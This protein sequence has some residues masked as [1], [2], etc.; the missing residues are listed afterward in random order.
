MRLARVAWAGEVFWA[1]LEGD[2]H[3]RHIRAPFDRWAGLLAARGAEGL[4]LAAEPI[5]LAGCRLLPPLEPGARAFGIGLNYLS[6]LE[7]LGSQ[8]PAHSLGY[9]K[10]ASA[11]IGAYDEIG[12][13]P[14]T[15]E[16]DY[17]VELVAVLARPL[18]EEP[19]ASACLLGYTVGNDIS[20]RDAGRQIA[21]LDLLTQK[22][23]DR[24]TPVGP[25]IVTLD[26]FGGAGQ[27][28]LE[29]SLS[30]NGERRQLD[31][32]R[33]MIFGIDELLNYV[34]ARI[35]LQPGDLLFTGSSHGVGLESGRFLE[36]GD[37][38]EARIEGIG[39]L[40]NRVGARRRL[41]AARSVGR[42]GM[43]VGP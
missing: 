27:P 17:E 26:E 35:T 30:V 14:L 36:P 42:L 6:H 3:L 32:T 43:P 12:Y 11:L 22:A 2:D 31:N 19:R 16:L 39:R 20:A 25:W 34:D 37:T 38:V 40:C 4:D 10:P 23:M 24:T 13:P 5:A 29:I 8:A 28:A 21:R 18:G 1:A 7:R 15:R 33:Q 9:I 41:P